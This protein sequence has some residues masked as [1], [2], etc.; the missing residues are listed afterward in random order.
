MAGL[1]PITCFDGAVGHWRVG[2]TS[3][4]GEERCRSGMVVVWVGIWWP[5]AKVW[6]RRA[7]C[8]W[9]LAPTAKNVAGGF[10][11]GPVSPEFYPCSRGGAVVRRSV[12]RRV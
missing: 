11:V 3:R 9:T 1:L 4:R 2:G 6:A 12:R 10:E 7:G 5:A 8:F